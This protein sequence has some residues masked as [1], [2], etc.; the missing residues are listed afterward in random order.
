MARASCVVLCDVPYEARQR[1]VPTPG[2]R[3]AT[4][5][6]CPLSSPRAACSASRPPNTA[7][8]LRSGA[9]VRLAGG[10]TGRHLAPPFGCRPELRQLH[11]LVRWRHTFAHGRS[12]G[13]CSG[14][15][16][17]PPPGGQNGTAPP[18][19]QARRPMKLSGLDRQSRV[20]PPVAQARQTPPRLARPT[21]ARGSSRRLQRRPRSSL[22]ALRLFRCAV[23][24]AVQSA[25]T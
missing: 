23:R 4:R 12:T 7:D 16:R 20:R 3:Y 6:P 25:A 13:P 21:S 11:P 9:P 5:R 10:G 14:Q 2:G 8:Q 17:P 1:D 24:R 19:R 18:P 22:H 15:I